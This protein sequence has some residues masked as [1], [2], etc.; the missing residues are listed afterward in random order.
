MWHGGAL[1]WAGQEGDGLLPAMAKLVRN[2]AREA[3]AQ[4]SKE[5]GL[6][7]HVKVKVTKSIYPEASKWT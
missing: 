3:V 4:A 7:E 1:S 5:I 6:K 2:A